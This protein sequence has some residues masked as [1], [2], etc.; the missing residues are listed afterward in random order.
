MRKVVFLVA[1]VGLA[2]MAHGATAAETKEKPDATVELSTGSVAVGVGFSWGGGELHYKGKNHPFS[3]EGLSVGDV[4]V[5]KATAKGEVFHLKNLS[6]FEGNY[7]AGA[8]G[9]TLGG[10]GGAAIMKNQ[11]G[12]VIE[13]VGTTQGLK[14]KL[15]AEGV[16]ITLKK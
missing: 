4:G 2:L 12:V 1:V 14:L 9:A 3:I 13:L 8:A 6:D 5:S 15:A 11:N 16:K 10:G 7:T